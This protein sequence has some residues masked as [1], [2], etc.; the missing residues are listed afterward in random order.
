MRSAGGGDITLPA[1][2]ARESF[3][4]ATYWSGSTSSLR[5]FSGPA[6]RH[7]FFNFLLTAGGGDITLL[8]PL[9]CLLRSAIHRSF[10]CLSLSLSLTLFL[11]HTHSLSCSLVCSRALSSERSPLSRSL[12][13]CLPISLI[14]SL[15][16]PPS[17]TLSLHRS[18]P[19]SM[20]QPRQQISMPREI[21]IRPFVRV[22]QGSFGEIGDRS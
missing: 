6:S 5:R 20:S 19:L 21:H 3:I 11:S 22:S 9:A 14:L 18:R 10:P 2:L 13:L 1:P 7:V 15:S 12:S 4:L 17:P 8:A 16:L